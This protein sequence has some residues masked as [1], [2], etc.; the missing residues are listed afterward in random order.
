MP[1][2]DPAEPIAALTES[3]TDFSEGEP[4]VGTFVFELL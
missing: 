1:T 4:F 3:D 2:P